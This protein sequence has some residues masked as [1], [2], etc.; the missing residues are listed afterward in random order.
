M[1]SRGGPFWLLQALRG[2]GGDTGFQQLGRLS[3]GW[4]LATGSERGPVG[5]GV[6]AVSGSQ[7]SQWIFFFFFKSQLSG[8]P[9]PYVS[10]P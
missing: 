6:E 5:C 10:F 2:C 4:A 3:W 8:N 9:S 1:A 7:L